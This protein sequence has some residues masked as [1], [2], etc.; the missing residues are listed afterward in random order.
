MD[1][2]ILVL[3]HESERI[4]QAVNP[5]PIKV[6]HNAEFQQGMMSSIRA[7]LT[8]VD[9]VTKGFFIVLGDQ[10]TIGVEVYNRLIE[11]FHRHYPQKS[12]FIPTHEGRRGHPALFAS[13]YIREAMEI[14][15]DTGLR[16]IIQK[17]PEDVMTLEMGTKSILDD[18]DTPEQYESLKKSKIPG[19]GS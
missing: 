8:A 17:H 10:P 7:G 9:P 14:E 18:L 5:Q 15:G 2:I 6:I 12:I 4:L 16:A 19:E 13:E 11:E 1:E 3:G